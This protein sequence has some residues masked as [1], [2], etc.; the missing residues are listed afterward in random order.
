[1]VSAV[2]RAHEGPYLCRAANE[3]GQA[4]SMIQVVVREGAG[5]GGGG[6]VAGAG[7][8]P[9][10]TPPGFWDDGGEPDDG[11]GREE[12]GSGGVSVDRRELSAPLGGNAELR[13]FVVGG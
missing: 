12:Q 1:M 8:R 7:T 4:E 2:T 3:A 9:G 13:C 5:G 6:D 11:A 10:Y